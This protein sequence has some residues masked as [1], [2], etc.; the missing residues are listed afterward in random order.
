MDPL[1]SIDIIK[2]PA[3]LLQGIDVIQI[4][5]WVHLFFFVRAQESLGISVLSGLTCIG[6]NKI[7][8]IWRTGSS[9]VAAPGTVEQAAQ[10]R[11]WVVLGKHRHDLPFL[12]D[13]E[14]KMLEAFFAASSSMVSRPTM[15]SSSTIRSCSLL[16]LR[17]VSKTIGARSRNSAFQ[18][19]SVWD[20]SRCSR[21][22]LAGLL[23]PVR[24]SSTTCA[25][26]SDVNVRLLAIVF[27]PF[28][29]YFT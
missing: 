20:L 29:T 25:L 27:P 18:R 23:T 16:L 12:F 24:S 14:V 11:D 8:L 2:E 26:K 9:V 17:F 7:R 5:G 15:H 6:H 10:H 3:N 13:R 28:W 22:I 4:L 19:E 1:V 21:Q